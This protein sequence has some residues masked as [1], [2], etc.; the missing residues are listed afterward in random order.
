MIAPKPPQR[1]DVL[2]EPPVELNV[3]TKHPHTVATGLPAVIKSMQVALENEG[4]VRMTQTML[5]INQRGGFDCPSC[6]WADPEG[7]RH[8]AEF[9]ENGAKA[10]ADDATRRRIDAEFFARYTVGQLSTQSDHWLNAQGRL[11]EPMVLYP[12][13]DKYEPISWDDAFQLVADELNA[14]DSPDE[15]AFYTSGKAVN[16]SAFLFQLFARMLGTNN[17]PDCSNMCHE[18]SGAALSETL[19]VGKST[20]TLSD[21]ENADCILVIGQNPGTNHP[22]MLSSLQKAK[23]NGA[24]MISINPLR[25]AGLLGFRH[26]Q[27][28]LGLLGVATKLTDHYLQ[29][30]INGDLALLKGFAKALLER[31]ERLP[32]TVLD[33]AFIEQHSAGFEAYAADVRAASWDEIVAESGISKGRILEIAEII[34]NAKGVVACWAMGLTQHKN[35]VPTIRELVNLMLLRGNVGRPAAGLLCVRGHSNVQGDRTMGIWEK[36]DDGFLDRLG[37]EFAFEPPREH[38]M[39][40]VETIQAMLAGKIKAFISLGGNFLSA[41]PDTHRVAE[42]LRNCRLTVSIATKLNRSHLVTGQTA[43]ILPCLS[44]T[45]RDEQASGLQIAT[46]ENTVSEVSATKG[47]LSPAAPTLRSEAAIVA[48]M[49]AATLRGKHPLDWNALVADY[50]T[51]RDHAS[52]VVKGFENFNA[53]VRGNEPFYAPVGPKQREFPTKSGKANFTVNAITTLDVREG[54]LVMMTMR[55]HD[56]FNTVVYGLDDRYRGIYG[57]RRIIFLNGEDVAERGLQDGQLVDITSRFGEELRTVEQFRV[58]VYDIP[59]GCAATYY[60]ETNPLVPLE[61]KADISGTPTSKSV[62]ITVTPSAEAAVLAS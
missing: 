47:L 58:V 1:R 2:V 14:M 52:R 55:T 6:A 25:E 50:D 51:I 13:A 29:V 37:E 43:L 38:G 22:R 39:D 49:A 3:V 16:E 48:G 45:E 34:A 10:M 4:P 62:I 21:L 15:A 35:A 20:V 28:P 18:S 46:V 24:T 19:G 56:Q 53:R 42:G 30:R 61:S 36:M 57:G 33:K 17:M 12:D 41:T 40:T 5:K 27:E 32:G 7:H 59:R 23:R 31:E 54:E 11:I 9:C 44:R 26:P 60:P 8:S